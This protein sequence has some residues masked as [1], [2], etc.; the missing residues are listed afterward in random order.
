MPGRSPEFS[1]D[2]IDWVLRGT[3]RQIAYPFGLQGYLWAIDRPAEQQY[4]FHHTEKS[5]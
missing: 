4:T 2:S 1:M 5:V 3:L